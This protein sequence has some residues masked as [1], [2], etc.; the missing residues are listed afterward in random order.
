MSV[1]IS[2]VN[3]AYY[4]DRTNTIT[5]FEKKTGKVHTTQQQ[6]S[7]AK[8]LQTAATDRLVFSAQPERRMAILTKVVAAVVACTMN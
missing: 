3:I 8:F 7:T 1:V 6:N 5:A 4:I 2:N